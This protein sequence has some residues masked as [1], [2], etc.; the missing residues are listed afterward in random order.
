MYWNIEKPR[1][2]M[3][4]LVSYEK[5]AE[6]R[7][8]LLNQLKKIKEQ[9]PRELPLVIDGKKV[10]TGNV[11]EIKAPHDHGTVLARAHLAGKEELEEAR[12]AALEAHREWSRM[13]HYHRAAIFKSAADLLAGDKRFENVAAIMMNQS[14]NAREAELDLAEM[15][16]FL[17]YNSY[18][19]DQI[20]REQP[21]QAPGEMNRLD[22]RP[23]E[24]FILAITPFNFYSIGGNL[25]TA[26]AMVGN[27]S[28]WKPSR[29]VL[30]SNYKIM[31][32]LLETG[33][34]GGVI[35]YVPFP[36]KISR[37]IIEDPYLGGIHF[38]GSYE[39]LVNIWQMV[40]NN[41]K[42]YRSFPRI[43]GESGGKD[44]L[45]MHESADVK[46]VASRLVEGAFGYQGQK[47]S[48]VSRAYVP[49][50]RW[51]DLKK[52]LLEETANITTGKVSNLDNFMGGL[53]DE[54][55]YRNVVSYLEYARSHEES[56]EILYGGSGDDSE[57]WYVEPTIIKTSAPDG[58]LMTEEIFGPVLTIYL[59]EEDE[60]SETLEICDSTSPYGLT[61]SIFA[62]DR[63]AILE[64][65]DKLKYAAGNFYINDKPTGAIVGRQPF[66]GS[67]H[68]G[69]NDK[70]GS[71]LNLLRWLSPRSIKETTDPFNKFS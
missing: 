38:T 58:K 42:S 15:I 5:G 28:L 45:F 48:A 65:E 22:W 11:Q 30:L 61:G 1:S 34:P 4:Q 57:G 69:T 19:A 18:F 31:E 23:L 39:T 68:S 49:R 46:M 41:L 55:A 27:T 70:A 62:R 29:S 33:L 50:N 47:C 52:D 60:Y 14:K 63:E 26:P 54:G 9:S 6:E 16:D 35:N 7:E 3:S 51:K 20:F 36:S 40:S 17:N 53:I 12:K 59:Y 66:G 10:K 37:T 67:R 8:R 56:Y 71:F 43:V 25:P 64:A 24:G 44:F 21:D 32:A 13:E 2:E